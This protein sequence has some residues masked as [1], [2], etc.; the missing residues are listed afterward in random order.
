MRTVRDGKLASWAFLAFIIVVFAG[1]LWPLQQAWAS[2]AFTA[3]EVGETLTLVGPEAQLVGPESELSYT[4]SSGWKM[5]YVLEED[6]SATI[7]GLLAAGT[8]ASIS[9][10]DSI[11]GHAVKALGE[12][13][14]YGNNEIST[15]AVSS[16][17]LPDTI[18]TLGASAFAA[19]G[20]ESIVLPASLKAVPQACF[21][22]CKHLAE[23][24]FLGDTLENIGM[25]SFSGCS[26]LTELVLPE[27]TTDFPKQTYRV[28][29]YCFYRCDNLETLVFKGNANTLSS[30]YFANKNCFDLSPKLLN[31][32]YYCKSSTA[33]SGTGS[34]NWSGMNVYTT[35]YFY[36][37]RED[38]LAARNPLYSI[39][40]LSTTKISD[41]LANTVD[42]SDLLDDEGNFKAKRVWDEQGA[43]PELP[44][45]REWGVGYGVMQGDTTTLADSNWVAPVAD[46]D[47]QSG[48]ITSEIIDDFRNSGASGNPVYYLDSDDRVYGID[49]IY[50]YGAGGNRLSDDAY[51]LVFEERYVAGGSGTQTRYDW[52]DCEVPSVT[53]TYRV[54]AV[55]KSQTN[56]GTRTQTVT[57]DVA[58]FSPNV[59]VQSDD[60]AAIR[61]ARSSQLTAAAARANNAKSA[62]VVPASDWRYQLIGAGL[63]GVGNG[64][65]LFDDQDNYS[66][67]TTTAFI[68]SDVDA[69]QVVGSKDLVPE[70]GL[71]TANTYLMDNIK[72]RNPRYMTRY[73]ASSS[74]QG[75]ADQVYSTI[76]GLQTSNPPKTMYGE[77]WGETAIVVSPEAVTDTPAIAQLAYTEKAPVFFLQANGMLSE[78]DL[79]YL[80]DDGFTRIV[81]AG[82]ESCISQACVNAIAQATS[83]QPE[84]K[85]DAGGDALSGALAEKSEFAGASYE[86][87]MVAAASDPANMVAAGV[88]A[89]AKG[90]IALPCACTADSKRIQDEL[91]AFIRENGQPSIKAVYLMGDFSGID[92]GLAERLASMWTGPQSTAIGV[93]D[94]VASKGFVYELVSTSQV[95]LTGRAD[96]ATGK[97]VLEL[98]D[99]MYDGAT[100]SVAGI[101]E[102]PFADD[103][104]LDRVTVKP[105]ISTLPD[106][107]FEGCDNL[108][109]V[110]LGAGVKTIGASAFKNCPK[111]SSV[112][113]SSA[114]SIGNSA[115]EGCSSLTTCAPLRKATSIGACAFKG[116][117]ALR[118]VRA[119]S[120]T[121]IGDSAFE[122]AAALGDIEAP[123]ATSAGAGAFRD[124]TALNIVELPVLAQMGASAF[125]GCTSLAT[126]SLPALTAVS[127]AGFKSCSSLASFSS[128][129]VTSIGASAFEYCTKL[130]TASFTSKKLNR[131]GARAFYGDKKMRTFKL[132]TKKLS[133]KKI[134]AKAFKGFGKKATA[135][136]PKSKVKAYRKIFRKKG[137]HKKSK[138]KKI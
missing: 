13:A 14:F 119:L 49:K 80:R 3:G 70:S 78:I 135:Y 31:F 66:S 71:S 101:G 124:C 50:A 127:D 1:W 112:T 105:G 45:G 113:G 41:I 7:T 58:R 42:H 33:A 62:V 76:R 81:V 118:S 38:A 104:A 117:S 116:A 83:V 93:G 133:S 9:V 97:L 114:A 27:L 69:V 63:A 122:G 82:D 53:G 94:T 43:F 24:E 51:D 134:G 25:A 29:T 130:R 61:L 30:R 65:V 96:A 8:D 26:S 125:E 91:A 64:V 137:M 128:S 6:G 19:S 98:N 123:L 18:E 21:A 90:G 11:D 95:K 115:F 32:V 46:D 12:K 92:P 103:D 136:V 67:R 75:T 68:E 36:A 85:F 126:I 102:S 108:T 40:C 106:G 56:V 132:K 57:I 28:G 131:I 16:I 39:T 87:A 89:A 47:L 121:S 54:S 23:V 77:G 88:L 20:I 72:A 15:E 107:M 109:R 17:V 84:R 2:D 59:I 111:L 99:A 48:W 35:M 79:G 55:G 73:G 37:T 120:A 4:D 44:E 22:G 60:D 52:R 74:P 5:A 138:V 86:Y 129:K 10:P 110:T 34:F 100:Y